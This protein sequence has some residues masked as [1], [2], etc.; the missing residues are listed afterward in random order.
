[1]KRGLKRFVFLAFTLVLLV[2]LACRADTFISAMDKFNCEARGGTWRQQVRSDGELAEW[3]ERQPTPQTGTG[4]ANQTATVPTQEGSTPPVSIEPIQEVECYAPKDTFAW[5]YQDFQKSSG[6][7]GVTCNARFVL[8]NASNEKVYLIVYTAWDNNTMKDSGWDT[9]Q[10]QA[11]GEWGM[12][13]SRTDY[14]DGVITY[15]KVGR[16]LVI[17]DAPE[18]AGILSEESQS[19]WE[20]QALDID[21]FTCP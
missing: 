20:A 11:G 7:G 1:M 18:C 15:S 3:C 9:H 16:I 19:T 6:T 4:D 14:T 13:V 8:S 10:V 5:S 12:K 21:E 2:Q 17:R